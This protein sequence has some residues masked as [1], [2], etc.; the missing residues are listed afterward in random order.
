MNR[1]ENEPEL[2]GGNRVQL[3]DGK[4]AMASVC[5]VAH[6]WGVSAAASNARA[7]PI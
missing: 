2:F 3:M 6:A 5:P 4:V 7:S 1:R